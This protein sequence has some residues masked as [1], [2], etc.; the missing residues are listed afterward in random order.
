MLIAASIYLLGF[1]FAIFLYFDNYKLQ[2][3][4]AGI[5]EIANHLSESGF[6][7]TAFELEAKL[8]QV[9]FN[10]LEAC[11]KAFLWPFHF[12]VFLISEWLKSVVAVLVN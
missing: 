7:N 1:L 8:I 12:L 9:N 5:K 4:K 2:I 11:L 10:W 6:T 3:Q